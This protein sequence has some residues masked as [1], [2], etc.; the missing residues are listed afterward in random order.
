[1]MTCSM[2][3]HLSSDHIQGGRE[4]L[5]DNPATSPILL[6][7]GDLLLELFMHI[8]FLASYILG[9]SRQTWDLNI[10]LNR[11]L[12]QICKNQKK[13]EAKKSSN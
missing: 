9:G 6:V 12:H 10:V 4:G 2:H 13:D 11:K 1:M 5:P 8:L 3:P 7:L